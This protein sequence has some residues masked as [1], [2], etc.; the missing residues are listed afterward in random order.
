MDTY[1]IPINYE[2]MTISKEKPLAA[3]LNILKLRMNMALRRQVVN[4]Y[5]IEAYVEPTSFCNLRCPACPTGLRL[6]LRP[7]VAI[8]LDVFR[9]IIDS[10]GPYLFRLHMYN[11]G[12]P[13]LHRHL[14]ELIQCAKDKGIEVIIS[15]NLNIKLSDDYIEQFIQSGLDK[16]IVSLD[17]TTKETYEKYRR[18]GDFNLVCENMQRIQA[19]KMRLGIRTPQI[20]WQFLVFRHNEHEITQALSEYKA[21]GADTISIAA[22]ILPGDPPFDRELEPSTKPEYNMYYPDHPVQRAIKQ[23]I[24]K[25]ATCSWLYGTFVLNPNGMVSS[26]CGVAEEK[27]DFANYSANSDFMSTWNSSTFKRA[28]G[29]FTMSAKNRPY[30][31]LT[32]GENDNISRQINGK[33]PKLPYPEN[34]GEIICQRCPMLH[35]QKVVNSLINQIGY[36]LV[37]SFLKS[38]VKKARYLLAYLLMGATDLHSVIWFMSQK[39]RAYLK[40]FLGR[41]CE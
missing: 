7:S 34:V 25:R 9:A 12:E 28:R 36:S 2:P 11:W 10:I 16:L 4:N 35:N 20:M 21:W 40:S 26:C 27:L 19:V 6:G 13:F 39:T 29:L 22:A 37:A 30:Q 15:S 18:G 32:L 3:Y 41:E 24:R 17:G 5:P 31:G 23:R 38:P 1:D 33:A 8:E 14:P